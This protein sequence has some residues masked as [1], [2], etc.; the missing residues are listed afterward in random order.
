VTELVLHAAAHLLALSD[1]GVD[2]REGRRRAGDAM[3]NGSALAA[4][5]RWVRAQGGD[6]DEEALP[7]ARLVR[8]VVAPRDGI[9]TRLAAQPIGTAALHLG[10][11]R[12]A[13]G[14]AVDHAVGV[15]CLRKRGDVVERGE[16]LAAIHGHDETTVVEAADTVLAAYE[17]GD[18]PPTERPIVLDTLT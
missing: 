7:V 2:R 10:A 5:E 12:H 18:E 11:G 6:P 13:K 16:P 17:L 4:Y 1:L 15:L 8:E 3:A 14:D 9:V